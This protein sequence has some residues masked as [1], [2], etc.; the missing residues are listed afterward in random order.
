M[1]EPG[2][3]VALGLTAG[4]EPGIVARDSSGPQQQ[5]LL[6]G[7]LVWSLVPAPTARRVSGGGI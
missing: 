7:P 1:H 2:T 6:A 5:L 4:L 3:L